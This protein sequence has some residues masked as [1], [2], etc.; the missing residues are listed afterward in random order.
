M[1]SSCPNCGASIETSDNNGYTFCPYCGSKIDTADIRVIHEVVDSSENSKWETID[2]INK[3]KLEYEKEKAEKK[4][5][6]DRLGFGIA[7]F[8]MIGLPFTLLVLW[9]AYTGA[10]RL[11]GR[12]SI[13]YASDYEGKNYKGVVK[14]LKALGFENITTVDLHDSGIIFNRNNTIESITVNGN[15]DFGEFSFFPSDAEIVI[16]YH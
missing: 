1:K 2:Q 4:E 12:T 15:P 7:L 10:N 14:K 8:F 6:D 11:I 16:T 9:G 5:K 13:G 3:R